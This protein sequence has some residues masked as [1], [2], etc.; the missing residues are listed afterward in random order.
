MNQKAQG[1]GAAGPQQMLTLFSLA[2]GDPLMSF[3]HSPTGF[4]L[5]L[6]LS[7]NKDKQDESAFWLKTGGGERQGELE[8]MELQSD[9]SLASSQVSQLCEIGRAHV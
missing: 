8:L 6:L 9:T 5:L 1:R 4:L 7:F 2:P 3:L